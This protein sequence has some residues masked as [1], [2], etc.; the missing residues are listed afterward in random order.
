MTISSPKKPKKK[1]KKEV[2]GNAFAFIFGG[3]IKYKSNMIVDG[4]RFES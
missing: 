4:E 1:K 2:I 3:L